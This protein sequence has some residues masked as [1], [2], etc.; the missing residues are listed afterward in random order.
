MVV[1][2]LYHGV[3]DG[4][5]R[6]TDGESSGGHVPACLNRDFPDLLDVHDGVR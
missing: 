6:I 2:G 4:N 3:T 1:S 5:G